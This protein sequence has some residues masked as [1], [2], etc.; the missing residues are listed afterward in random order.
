M[1]YANQGQA[2]RALSTIGG[3][4][5]A[6]T[7]AARLERA[8]RDLNGQCQRIE[9]MLARV[10]GTPRAVGSQNVAQEKISTTA[11]LAASVEAVE[12]VIKRLAELAANLEGVA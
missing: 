11:P 3:A 7:M 5:A 12:I 4:P 2:A 6:P 8:A 9:D 1:E 10:N